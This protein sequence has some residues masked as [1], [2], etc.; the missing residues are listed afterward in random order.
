MRDQPAGGGFQRGSGQAVAEIRF[1]KP[2]HPQA[3]GLRVLAQPSETQL[4]GRG[5]QNNDVRGPVPTLDEIGMGKYEAKRRVNGLAGLGRRR[6]IGTGDQI[7]ARSLALAVR[8]TASVPMS[9]LCCCHS[10][11]V[12]AGCLIEQ[13]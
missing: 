4:V 2:D 13:G 5:Q 1:V 6:Q 9:G 12:T 3:N 10:S 7:Q 8:H 11:L